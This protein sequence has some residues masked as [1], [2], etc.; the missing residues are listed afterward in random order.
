MARKPK[1]APVDVSAA[2]K[3]FEALTLRLES[4][5]QSDPV[6]YNR[7]V[8]G[9]ATLGYAYIFAILLICTALLGGLLAILFLAHRFNLGLL[10][11]GFF[12]AIFTFAVVKS[13]F[14]R[15]E[16]PEGRELSREEAPQLF[17]HIDEIGQTLNAP[18][19]HHVLLTDEFNAAVSQVPRFGIFG[20]QRNYLIVGLQ[21]MAALSPEEFKSVLAHEFGH[22]SANH[23]KFS[24][25]VYRVRR[26]WLNLMEE[27]GDGFVFGPFF[28]WYAPYFAAYSFVLARQNEYVADRCAAEICGAPVAAASL[29]RGAVIGGYLSENFWPQLYGRTGREAIPPQGIYRDLMGAITAPLETSHSQRWLTEAICRPTDTV[30]THPS[31][32]QRLES[33]GQEA[34]FEPRVGP[35]AAQFYLGEQLETLTAQLEAQWNEVVSPVWKMRHDEMQEARQKLDAIEEKARSGELSDEE[36]WDRA[37]A[38]EDFGDEDAAFGLFREYL[39]RHP[40]E[41]KAQFAVGRLALKNGDESGLQNLERAIE[42]EFQATPPACEIAES[43]LLGRNRGD[44]AKVW[45]ERG[46]EYGDK[47]DYAQIERASAAVNDVFLPPELSETEIAALREHFAKFES[48][49]QVYAARKQVQHFPTVPIYLLG[50]AID[51]KKFTVSSDEERRSKLLAEALA[52]FEFPHQWLCVQLDLDTGKNFKKPLEK[53]EGSRLYER[54][55]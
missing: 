39:A 4:A 38:T 32:Q 29:A 13:L 2:R 42:L 46:L 19:P 18:K 40:E 25:W 48:V 47:L 7:R 51:K 10:K 24:G 28:N 45:R 50:I 33:L 14:V 5:A 22:L 17:A 31:L 26:T 52:E 16:P 11:I 30:D 55:K 1:A 34:H 21:L 8:A 35:S 49:T 3:K 36:A 54:E 27:V 37:D 9:L 15:I 23:S 43:F 41:A 20:G 53:V 6:A 12:V 44:E